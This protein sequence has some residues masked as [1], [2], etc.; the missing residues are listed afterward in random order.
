MSDIKFLDGLIVKEHVFADG[1][2]IQKLAFN[3]EEVIQTLQ[4]NAID[5]WVNAEINKSKST[6]KLYCKIDEW[7]KNN[8]QPQQ[9]NPQEYN[10]APEDNG[11]PEV[12]QQAD[13]NVGQLDD[14][15]DTIPF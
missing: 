13:T 10:Q 9:S 7:K 14:E 12:P 4:A 8:P 15:Q 5:G 3:V 1:N 6:G 11:F 2:A